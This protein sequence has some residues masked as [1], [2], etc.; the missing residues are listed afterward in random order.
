MIYRMF[1]EKKNHKN[2][3]ALTPAG[4]FGTSVVEQSGSN[5]LQHKM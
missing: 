4:T 5:I 3:A 2:T 1:K